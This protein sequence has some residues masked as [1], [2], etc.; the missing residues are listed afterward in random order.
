MRNVKG[1]SNYSYLRY[2]WAVD[3]EFCNSICLSG[4][5]LLHDGTIE[6]EVNGTA[7]FDGGFKV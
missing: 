1:V 5:S 6:I 2:L 7:G 4:F 3:F